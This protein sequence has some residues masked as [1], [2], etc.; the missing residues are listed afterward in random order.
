M[1]QRP[2]Q[3]QFRSNGI[4]GLLFFILVLI[5]LFY[6]AKG[7]FTLLYWASPLLII[8]AL[9]IN[10]QTVTGFL[11][12][13]WNLIRRNPLGGILLT[14]LAAVAFPVTFGFLFVKAIFDRKVRKVQSEMRKHREGE[15]IDYEIVEEEGEILDL[16]TLPPSERKKGS[17]YDDF[18]EDDD[19]RRQ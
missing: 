7:I 14:I 16:D 1:Q 19:R 9:L 3:F 13:L 6:L 2:S 15:L 5:A 4:V 17:S 11:K 12:F 8:G 18:F 10:Y